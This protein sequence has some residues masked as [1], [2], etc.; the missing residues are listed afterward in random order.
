M[1]NGRIFEDDV[2]DSRKMFSASASARPATIMSLQPAQIGYAT[3]PGAER[4]GRDKS[5]RLP[6]HSI[7]EARKDSA[8]RQPL[9]DAGQCYSGRNAAYISITVLW[10]ATP[11][12]SAWPQINAAIVR[13]RGNLNSSVRGAALSGSDFCR[14]TLVHFVPSRPT[15]LKRSAGSSALRPKPI[16]VGIS[17][18]TQE[19]W[20]ARRA[21]IMTQEPARLWK[22]YIRP[23][24]FCLARGMQTLVALACATR[25]AVTLKATT[26]YTSSEDNLIIEGLASAFI[27][28]NHP[29]SAIEPLEN[30]FDAALVWVDSLRVDPAELEGSPAHS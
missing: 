9:N 19:K 14:Q 24:G 4:R 28:K 20:I 25:S 6:A 18:P 21:R 5:G 23:R 7:M 17:T 11:A 30:L 12:M 22:R 27:R 29:R 16:F 26:D 8:F 2:C 3:D 1:A 10:Y 13:G 15:R